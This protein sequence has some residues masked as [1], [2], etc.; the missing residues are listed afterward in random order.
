V[1]PQDEVAVLLATAYE[2][3]PD[4]ASCLAKLP[5]VAAALEK[6][7]LACAMI[8]ALYLRLGEIPQER[9]ARLVGT[10][11]LLKHGFD[12]TQPRDWHGRWSAEGG[13]SSTGEASVVDHPALMP[14]QELL[15]FGARPP[16]FFDEPPKTFRP[17]K[18][19]IPRLSG[20]EGAKQLP[21]WARGNRP[22]VG[23]N[24]RDFA[25]RLMDKQYGRGNWNR[26]DPEYNQ[27]KKF[28]D[29]NFRD[30]RSILLPDDDHI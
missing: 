20:K 6:G 5:Q 11:A 2:P 8:A 25:E 21:S 26:T 24:G 10:E 9:V 14:V 27:L 19:P 18:E 1:R 29:R 4:L 22:Y 16:L 13:A 15:P 23:E 7:D 17:F 28:G 3:V 12:P 30:P